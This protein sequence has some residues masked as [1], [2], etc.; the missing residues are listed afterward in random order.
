MRK[1]ISLNNET[2]W[3][4]AVWK[5]HQ[6]TQKNPLPTWTETNQ[7]RNSK[8]Q[9]RQKFLPICCL[10]FSLFIFSEWLNEDRVHEWDASVLTTIPLI[11]CS[12]AGGDNTKTERCDASSDS[13]VLWTSFQHGGKTKVDECVRAFIP[14]RKHSCVGIWAAPISRSAASA[15]PGTIQSIHR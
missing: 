4:I 12:T 3:I 5:V 6:D 14:S 8:H 2:K 15:A 10:S 11:H 7:I 1:E 13:K 9:N